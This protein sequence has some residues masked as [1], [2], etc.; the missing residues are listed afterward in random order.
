MDLNI[1]YL[2]D[3]SA[4]GG[5]SLAFV[6]ENEPTR[7]GERSQRLR[8]AAQKS[9]PVTNDRAPRVRATLD[10]D[11]EASPIAG[12]LDDGR[13]PAQGFFGWLGLMAALE[14]LVEGA[15][16]EH[17]TGHGHQPGPGGDK[18]DCGPGTDAAK[19][20]TER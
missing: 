13:G 2:A 9:E 19:V 4:R 5:A 3:V 7:P 1:S 18:A 6:F 16:N 8:P 20:D 15:G 10:I 17:A 14:A 12:S 11:V